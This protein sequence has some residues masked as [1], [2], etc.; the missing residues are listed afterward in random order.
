MEEKVA[1]FNRLRKAMRIT[2]PQNKRGLNDNGELPSNIKTIQKEVGDFTARLSKCKACS[3][4]KKY[5]KLLEQIDTYFEKLFA[6]PI[7]VQTAAG[8]TVSGIKTDSPLCLKGKAMIL[9]SSA[10]RQ[11][12]SSPYGASA[13][14]S[15]KL[16]NRAG[17]P[18]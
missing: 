13:G 4:G 10:T 7:I 17:L 18:L 1:V 6:D 15:G 5:Q 11:E 9:C 12:R 3:G 2:L 8:R 16:S 14:R